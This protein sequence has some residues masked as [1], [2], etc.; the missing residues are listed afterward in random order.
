MDEAARPMQMVIDGLE[1][2]P[3]STVH[4]PSIGVV[5]WKLRD[6]LVWTPARFDKFEVLT[7]Y[8]VVDIT[9]PLPT[10]T[11]G[12]ATGKIHEHLVTKEMQPDIAEIVAVVTRQQQED[13]W[14][15]A[16]AS[17]EATG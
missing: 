12:V 10:N 11:K 8:S 14:D 9:Y 15:A 1:V 3:W 4:L 7:R 16:H 2:D 17:Q 13:A 6:G 5:P